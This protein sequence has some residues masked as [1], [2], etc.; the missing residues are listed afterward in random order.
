MFK[1]RNNEAMTYTELTKGFTDANARF[2]INGYWTHDACSV[3]VKGQSYLIGGAYD[4][5]TQPEFCGHLNVQRAVMKLSQTSCG[6]DIVMDG[7]TKKLPYS[8]KEHSCT[9]FQKRLSGQADQE[10]AIM[11]SPTD[12]ADEINDGME[13]QDRACWSSSDMVVWEREPWLRFT[14]IKATMKYHKGYVV[15]MGGTGLSNDGN[16]LAYNDHPY[17]EF[18]SQNGQYN[19]TDGTFGTWIQGVSLPLTLEEM[20]SV[21]DGEHL[22]VFGGLHYSNKECNF[23][24]DAASCNSKRVY[25]NV[26]PTRGF[27]W[28]SYGSLM[29]TRSRF[30]SILVGFQNQ[31]PNLFHVAGYAKNGLDNDG[32]TISVTGRTIEK[33]W[34]AGTEFEAEEMIAPDFSQVRQSTSQQFLYDFISPQTFIISAEWFNNYC[35]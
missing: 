8:M 23:W 29:N 24:A 7:I 33:W 32:N 18:L 25:R 27:T 17:V 34:Q 6:L 2:D 14:H 10:R 3:V 9:G 30:S 5:T 4:C 26:D 13:Y 22:Y 1:W 35:L 31:V 16:I 19:T 21:T 12:S 11:C 28:S 15:I 20:T